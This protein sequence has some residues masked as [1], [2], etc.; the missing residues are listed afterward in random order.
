MTPELVTAI[1]AC[2]GSVT[3][4]LGAVKIYLNN[5][6]ENKSASTHRKADYDS[7]SDRLT[8]IEERQNS[9]AS[10]CNERFEAGERRFGAQEKKMDD[11]FVELKN[12]AKGVSYI[13]GV[14]DGKGDKR[15]G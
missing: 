1:V 12:V 10:H 4:L 7:F 11:I 6:A 13:Q 8:R 15:C 5:K 9:Y 2:L 14:L 3:S